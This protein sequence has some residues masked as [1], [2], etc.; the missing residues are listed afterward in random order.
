MAS[1]KEYKALKKKYNKAGLPFRKWIGVLILIGIWMVVAP[2]QPLP[3]DDYFN[4][5]IEEKS[6]DPENWKS[7]TKDLNYHEDGARKEDSKHRKANTRGTGTDEE[8]TI[9]TSGR[10][11]PFWA[12]VFKFLVIGLAI[13][14]IAILLYHVL[15]Q[16][17]LFR[18]QGRKIQTAA[19]SFSI[20]TIEANIH[21]SD[22][23]RHIRQ[24]IEQQNYALAIRLYYLAVIKALS[25]NKWIKWKRD[26]TNRDYLREV[27][28][29]A[30]FQPYREATRIFERVWYGNTALGETD[31]NTLKPQFVALLNDIQQSRA[32]N[33]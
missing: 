18:P 4:Q 10:M 2:A 1:E 12:M 20:E 7:L 16:G 32:T 24:A 22:L 5:T 13:A 33:S 11:S 17:S 27:R 21:E 9:T 30:F 29:T 23:D 14:V 15:G 25:L 19:D 8:E 3:R 31:F 6:F 26:K 28:S